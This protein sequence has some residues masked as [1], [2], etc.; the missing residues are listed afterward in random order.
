M[1]QPEHSFVVFNHVTNSSRMNHFVVWI[2]DN[3]P[4]PVEVLLFHDFFIKLKISDHFN[5]EKLFPETI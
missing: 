2:Q 5:K 1:I 3:L 4:N